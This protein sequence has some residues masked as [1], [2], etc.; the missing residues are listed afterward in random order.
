MPITNFQIHEPERIHLLSPLMVSDLMLRLEVYT[1]PQLFPDQEPLA[2]VKKH[3]K[4]LQYDGSFR[5]GYIIDQMQIGAK[6]LEQQAALMDVLY[7]D[8]THAILPALREQVVQA[9]IESQRWV[10]MYQV[11]PETSP[12]LPLSFIAA[13]QVQQ[14]HAGYHFL[15]GLSKDE[16]EAEWD[17]PYAAFDTQ[18]L[19]EG[20]K[21]VYDL[22]RAWAKRESEFINRL[23]EQGA[24]KQ[25]VCLAYPVLAEGLREGWNPADKD[26]R[27][28]NYFGKDILS[29]QRI[30]PHDAY[31]I[32]INRAH[33]EGSPCAYRS[34]SLTFEAKSPLAAILSVDFY[35]QVMGLQAVPVFP[36]D[37]RIESRVL[38]YYKFDAFKV[39]AMSNATIGKRLIPS[40]LAVEFFSYRRN[41]TVS[42]LLGVVDP[43][44]EQE[45]IGVVYVGTLEQLQQAKLIRFQQ[46]IP[47]QIFFHHRPVDTLA[48]PL[49]ET[50]GMAG[51]IYMVEQNG[52]LVVRGKNGDRKTLLRFQTDDHSSPL[53]LATIGMAVIQD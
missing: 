49:P 41:I 19:R 34:F 24:E 53:L 35:K 33:R 52:S 16:A 4:T 36:Q 43:D 32:T 5:D 47:R 2:L 10:A 50:P 44:D 3:A 6:V 40:V 15:V 11:I 37:E 27:M 31:R 46:G 51:A 45:P 38:E 8:Q 26:T 29:L 13:W 7:C 30:S 12:Q 14:S 20:I 22:Y 9:I 39:T 1:V 48:A 23:F 18:D 17:L 21:Q 28:V 25:P 42:V